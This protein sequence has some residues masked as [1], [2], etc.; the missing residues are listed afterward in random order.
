MIKKG[1]KSY[2]GNK[3]NAKKGITGNFKCSNC[4]RIYKQQW[5][6]DK[7]EKRCKEQ[8]ED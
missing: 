5:T 6:K 1:N 2:N 8:K 4:G 3:D 7:H